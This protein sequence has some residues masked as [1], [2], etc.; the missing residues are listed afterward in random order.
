MW[1]VSGRAVEGSPASASEKIGSQNS[2]EIDAFLVQDQL[3]RLRIV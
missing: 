2:C 3:S 1:M